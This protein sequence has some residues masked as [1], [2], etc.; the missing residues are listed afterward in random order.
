MQKKDILKHWEGTE[1]KGQQRIR[2]KHRVLLFKKEISIIEKSSDF[3]FF[4]CR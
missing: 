4:L 2:G 3:F 1:K